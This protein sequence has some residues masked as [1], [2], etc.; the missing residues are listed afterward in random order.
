LTA[1]PALLLHVCRTRLL[2]Y[3]RLL[4]CAGVQVSLTADDPHVGTFAALQWHLH[5]LRRSS[6][7]HTLAIH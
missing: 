1:C 2:A 6:T 4:L 7:A 5:V 3:R